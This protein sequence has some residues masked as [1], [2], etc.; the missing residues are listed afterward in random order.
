MRP[1]QCPVSGAGLDTRRYKP[2]PGE[3]EQLAHAAARHGTT[4]GGD[5]PP[6]HARAAAVGAQVLAA[7]AARSRISKRRSARARCHALAL[8]L[9]LEAMLVLSAI[10]LWSVS[11]SPPFFRRLRTSA[12]WSIQ[13]ASQATSTAAVGG[14][15]HSHRFRHSRQRSDYR[16]I[17]LRPP[18]PLVHGLD[19]GC[20]WL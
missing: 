11:A 16:A 10:S 1:V 9:Q 2:C 5:L 19:P 8:E 12:A 14:A 3:G 18:S 20:A 17:R 15:Q 6:L 13:Q 7:I 4:C